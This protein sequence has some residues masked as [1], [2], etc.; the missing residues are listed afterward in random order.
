MIVRVGLPTLAVDGRLT[1]REIEAQQIA[2]REVVDTVLAAVPDGVE[3]GHRYQR[4][5]FFSARVDAAGLAALA[6]ASGVT[7][8]E[9]D[10]A[11]FPTLAQSV[12]LINAPAAWSAGSTGAGWKVAVLD[13]GVQTS[14]PFLAGK[15]VSEACY[16]NSGGVGLQTSVCPGGVSISTASG[17]GVNC[18]IGGCEHGTHIAGI[19]VGQGASANGAAPAASLIAMQ[20]FTQFNSGCGSDVTPCARSFSSD[21]VAA[22]DRVA[23]LAGPGNANQIASVNMSLGGGQFSDQATC[24]SQ[25]AARK[26]A[27]DN[28]RSLGIA[29]VISAGNSAFTSSLTAPGCI[30]SAVSVGST[31]KSD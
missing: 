12:P 26:A 2:I 31:T 18:G 9:E 3:V 1:A 7:S 14:H 8:I 10:V 24:D 20:V 27:I 17:S 29:T 22:L 6:R 21:Q 16:S 30:S 19:A 13:T 11:D 23:V 15:T 5:P 28:L 4:I 25:H